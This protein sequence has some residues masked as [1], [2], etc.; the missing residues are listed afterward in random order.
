MPAISES[1]SPLDDDDLAVGRGAVVVVEAV[2]VV[3]G[4]VVGGAVV[5]GAVVTIVVVVVV[6]TIVVVV[7]VVTVVVVTESHAVPPLVIKMRL[8]G[9]LC[10]EHW[11]ASF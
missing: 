6:V 7:V 8:F 4:A 5:V 10:W 3:A 1:L 9:K 2:E 11:L